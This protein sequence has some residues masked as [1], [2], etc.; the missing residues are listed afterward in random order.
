MSDRL[1]F[2]IIVPLYNCEDLVDAMVE[3]FN[4]Q[5]SFDFE[6]IFVNDGS[7]DGT[8]QR[9]MQKLE[10]AAF[11]HKVHTQKNAGPGEARNTGMALA[12][13]EYLLFVDADDYLVPD[14]IDTLRKSAE[15]THADV[16][17]FGYHQ[18]FYVT[19]TE[20]DHRVTVVPDK[21][22]LTGNREIVAAV[23][24][25]DEKKGFSCAWNKAV[26]RALA[27]EKAMKFSKRMHSEDYFFYIELFHHVQSLAVLDRALYHYIKSPRETLT[28]QPYLKNFYALITDRYTAMQNLLKDAGVYA[29]E[30]AASAANTHIKHI[31]SHFSNNCSP[32]SGLQGREIRQDIQR[33]L[34]DPLT[35]E[36]L[37]LAN[38]RSRAQK[39]MNALLKTKSVWVCYSFAKGVSA[40]RNSKLFDKMK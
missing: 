27:A 17:L 28:N 10:G 34:T 1:F 32:F 22:V 9:L 36:A 5:T 18:D 33:T 25:L 16:L 13:G 35:A 7:K 12:A 24:L 14:A 30:S 39:I 23:P 11:A 4:E 19:E 3:H 21:R 29:G 38:A 8:L 6:V 15:E 20:L 37:S 40:M 31:F 26:K 2:S